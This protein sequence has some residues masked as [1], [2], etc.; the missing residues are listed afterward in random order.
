MKTNISKL[1]VTSLTV[2][3]IFISCS[4]EVVHVEADEESYFNENLTIRTTQSEY[5]LSFDSN[6]YYCSVNATLIN[7]TQDT[8]Y[9]KLGDG[10]NE[11][12][13]QEHLIIAHQTD[14]YFEYN[15]DNNNWENTEQFRL[16]E[17]S[18]IIRILPGAQYNI[19]AYSI[20][21]TNKLGAYRLKIIYYNNSQT[22]S[23]DT[24][25]DASNTFYIYK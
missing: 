11:S 13:D 1:T 21:D 5:S 9:S 12:F 16:F 18:K 7:S 22:Q 10:F 14:G 3:L 8:F 20:I 19:S 23:I 25:R 15:V 17:G 4:N 6:N 24:L 2:L